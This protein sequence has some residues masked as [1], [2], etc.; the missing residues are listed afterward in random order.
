[1]AHLWD[2]VNVTSKASKGIQE[3]CGRHE[4]K[5]GMMVGEWCALDT[6]YVMNRPTLL[7]WNQRPLLLNLAHERPDLEQWQIFPSKF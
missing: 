1:M 6:G 3:K 7:G 4:T 2:N 5:R